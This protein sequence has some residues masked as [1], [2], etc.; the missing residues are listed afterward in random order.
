MIL[1]VGLGNPGSQYKYT[2][3]NLGFEVIDAFLK[4]HEFPQFRESKKCSSLISEK[5]DVILAKPQTFMNRSGVAVQCLMKKH[6]PKS[7]IVIHDEIDLPQEQVRVAQN[8]GAAGHKGVQSI[9]TELG[10]QDFLRIRIGIQPE[11]GKPEGI[12]DFVLKK[13][14]KEEF[15]GSIEESLSLIKEI[16]FKEKES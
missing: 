1:I 3:H 6:N 5:E 8:K 15:N 14:K 4:K 13:Y 9:I 10:T 7:L 16:L 11:S 12:E 2:Y